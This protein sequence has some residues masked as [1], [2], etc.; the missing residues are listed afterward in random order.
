[1]RVAVIVPGIMGSTLAYKD[2]AGAPTEIW[3]EDFYANY[4]RILKHP[5]RLLLNDKVVNASV[6]ETV[7]IS[8]RGH[9]LKKLE[10]WKLLLDWLATYQ[11]CEQPDTILKLGYDWRQSLVKSSVDFADELDDHAAALAKDR[12]LGSDELRFTFITHSMGG[13]LL[14]CAIGKELIATGRIDRIIHIGAPLE[15][16]PKSFVSTYKTGGLPGL[17][18]MSHFFHPWKNAGQFFQKAL[19]AMQTFPSAYQLM[20]PVGHN[21]LFYSASQHTNPFVDPQSSVRPD[22]TAAAAEV[23]ALLVKAEG[24]IRKDKLNQRTYTIYTEHHSYED[25]PWEFEV[26]ARD[27]VGGGYNFLHDREIDAGDG[28]VPASSA[29]GGIGSSTPKA[30]VNVTHAYMCND[31]QVV[32]ILPGII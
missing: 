14:R 7:D 10:I 22:M 20:P 15:G 11:A 16:A 8:W 13:L 28:T 4:E 17:R 26:S 32:D 3:G 5:E 1:V 21:F 12:S 19:D 6:L 25:T 18:E 2:A 23:Q 9:R 29:R 27:G 24:F 30:V 31:K